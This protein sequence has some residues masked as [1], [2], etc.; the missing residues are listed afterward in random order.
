MLGDNRSNSED[1]HRWGLL[2]QDLI[3][4]TAWVVI[5]PFPKAGMVAHM[6][7][8]VSMPTALGP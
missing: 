2:N 6:E 3:I 4:G 5:Y 8:K 1:S 7:P